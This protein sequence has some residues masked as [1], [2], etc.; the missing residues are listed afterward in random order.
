MRRITAR[1]YSLSS[2]ALSCRRKPTYSVIQKLSQVGFYAMNNSSNDSANRPSNKG[3]PSFD[4]SCTMG[5]S[6]R[7]SIENAAQLFL[8]LVSQHSLEPSPY[9]SMMAVAGQYLE[10][11]N[12]K[13]AETIYTQSLLLAVDNNDFFNQYKFHVALSKLYTLLDRYVE[14]LREA[15]QATMTARHPQVSA[16]LV[17]SLEVEARRAVAVNDNRTAKKVVSEGLKITRNN[18]ELYSLNQSGFLIIRAYQHLNAEEFDSANSD[19]GEAWNFLGQFTNTSILAGVHDALA[20]WHEAYAL[21]NLMKGVAPDSINHFRRALGHYRHLTSLPQLRSIYTQANLSN[22]LFR[23]AQFA[24]QMNETELSIEASQENSSI[25]QKIGLP[26][27][28]VDLSKSAKTYVVPP[29]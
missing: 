3:C 2:V 12:W 18:G 1:L 13:D 25:R 21:L 9:R 14:A 8:D 11:G 24:M 6:R 19:L 5:L 20:R 7:D 29:H 22:F 4:R 17:N 16:W 23:Y 10:L 28:Q 27:R 15:S 26:P